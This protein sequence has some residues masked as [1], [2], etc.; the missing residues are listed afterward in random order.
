MVACVGDEATRDCA[1]PARQIT[2]EEYWRLG[3][4]GVLGEKV[5]LI[6]GRIMFGNY[7]FAFSEERSPQHARRAL[8][9]PHR[10]YMR[11]GRDGAS[12]LRQKRCRRPPPRCSRER[13]RVLERVVLTL[14]QDGGASLTLAA[15][16]GSVPGWGMSHW[17]AEQSL[18]AAAMTREDVMAAVIR[19]WRDVG[20]G[21]RP[22]APREQW[23]GPNDPFSNDA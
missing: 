17:F 23:V 9:S 2:A 21:W 7:P 12:G 13:W 1:V 22:S 18:S 5:E 11:S 8:S 14:T 20:A 10:P 3:E 16:P 6:E 15:A 19:Y 4:I